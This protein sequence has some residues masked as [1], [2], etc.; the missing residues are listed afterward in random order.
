MPRSHLLSTFLPPGIKRL[1]RQGIYTAYYPLHDGA[2]KLEK[3]VAAT[4]DSSTK[5]TKR[6]ELFYEWSRPGAFYKE[7]PYDAIRYCVILQLSSKISLY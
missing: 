6:Q 5:L 4:R 1:F 2:Y 7:Q 3:E